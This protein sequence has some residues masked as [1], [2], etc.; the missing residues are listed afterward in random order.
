M[1]G[2]VGGWRG[3]AGLLAR[4][5]AH[6]NRVGGNGDPAGGNSAGYD[7]FIVALGSVNPPLAARCIAESGGVRPGNGTVNAVQ[8]TLVRIAT[9]LTA[10]V[11]NATPPA[12]P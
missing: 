8:A 6:A 5:L 9:S 2:E 4:R 3:L 7:D 12:T 10:P 11:K 1:A